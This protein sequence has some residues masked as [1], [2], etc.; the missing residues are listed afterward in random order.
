MEDLGAF[1]DPTLSDE[2]WIETTPKQKKKERTKDQPQRG[3]ATRSL[4]FADLK[5]APLEKEV[6]KE[7]RKNTNGYFFGTVR[8]RLHSSYR[9]FDCL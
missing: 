9:C 4:T 7:S 8:T 1:F 6:A 5:S 3:L 2:P